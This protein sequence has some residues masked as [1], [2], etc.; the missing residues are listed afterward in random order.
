[1][2]RP[3]IIDCDTGTDD[4]IAL[5]AAFG[6]PEINVRAITSVNGNVKEEY[7]SANNLNLTEYLGIDVEVARGATLPFYPRGDYYGPT[8]GKTGLGDVVIPDAKETSF[9]RDM[10]PE[11]IHRIA[12]EE[13][14]ELELLVIGPMT[15]IAIAISLYPQ[16]KQQIKHIWFMGGAVAGGNVSSTAE[17]N[18]WVDPTSAKMVTES[19]I[20]MTM[21]GLD[22]TTK[23]VLG[24]EDEQE[25]RAFGS[26]ASVLSADI[27]E[28]MFKRCKDGGEDALMHDALALAA[29]VIPE[30]LTCKEAFLDVECRGEYTAGHTVTDIV[31]RSLGKAPNASVA[32][33]LHL[34]V[35]RK[36]LLECIKRC[37][38]A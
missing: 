5:M 31:G 38:Q 27:L 25:L 7:T 22:V 8:H 34:D 15:N 33:E 24:R 6:C 20:P 12:E 21:V 13:N 2:K 37:G 10:A 28:Y 3:F 4:A 30:C 16:L 36:W 35:F 19:G 17:F 11:V 32:V 29:A 23:A 18:I 9:S 26:K 1:M 14:G